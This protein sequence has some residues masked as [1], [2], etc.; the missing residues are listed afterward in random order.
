M[1][2]AMAIE[3]E[4]AGECIE[5]IRIEVGREMLRLALVC[6][7]FCC[8]ALSALMGLLSGCADRDCARYW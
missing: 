6:L 3:G 8:E 5:R 1:A 4:V 7:A 2:F